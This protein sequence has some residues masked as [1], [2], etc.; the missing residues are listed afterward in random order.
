V[1]KHT[2]YYAVY[3]NASF[4]YSDAELAVFQ[5]KNGPN[6]VCTTNS[7]SLNPINKRKTLECQVV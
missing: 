5:K 1:G 3:C 4:S 7:K 6:F 2:V